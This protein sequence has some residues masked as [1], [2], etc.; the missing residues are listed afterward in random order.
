MAA[1]LPPH[2]QSILS[3]ISDFEQLR[4]SA[5]GAKP[6]NTVNPFELPV[7]KPRAGEG[8]KPAPA[9]T[10]DV[11]EI[12]FPNTGIKL[13]TPVMRGPSNDRTLSSRQAITGM[14]VAERVATIAACINSGD[15]DRAEVLYHRTARTTSREEMKEVVSTAMINAFVDAFLDPE[16]KSKLGPGGVDLTRAREWHGRIKEYDMAPDATTYAI[17]IKHALSIND[18]PLTIEFVKEMEKHGLDTA[19]LLE[20]RRFS[21]PEDRAPLESLLRGLGRL[22]LGKT[23][24]PESIVEKLLNTVKDNNAD[25]SMLEDSLMLSAIRD[26][27]EK[28]TIEEKEEEEVRRDGSKDVFQSPLHPLQAEV[29]K[30][31][32][33][34]GVNVLRKALGSLSRNPSMSPLERQRELEEKSLLAAVEE[35]EAEMKKMPAH[36]REIAQTRTRLAKEW[37]SLLVPT[38]K[39]ELEALENATSDAEEHSYV[40]FLRLLTPEQMS[41][42][43]ITEFLRLPEKGDKMAEHAG[44]TTFTRLLVSIGKAIEREYNMQQLS[45]PKNRKHIHELHANGKLFNRTMRK[46]ISQFALKDAEDEEKENWIPVWPESVY[47]KAASVLSV[48]LMRVAKI[49]VLH[50]KKD[51]PSEDITVW[52]PAFIHG[53]EQKDL[54][55]YGVI[56]YNPYL[57]EKLAGDPI[58]VSPRLL[59]MIIKPRPW[60]TANSGGYVDFIQNAVRTGFNKEHSDYIKQADKEQKLNKVYHCLDVLGATPWR[61]NERVYDVIRQVW[62]DG[63]GAAGIPSAEIP[64]AMPLKPK[65]VETWDVAK[66]KA[67]F[68]ERRKVESQRMTMF[69]Q[70]CDVNYKIEIARAFL[71]ETIYFPHNLDFRGRAYPMP[72]HLNH[73]GN[74]VCRGLLLFDTAKPL[75]PTGLRWLKIQVASLAGNDKVSFQDRI[76]FADEH[77]DDIFDAADNPLGGRRWWMGGEE[78]WQLLACCFELADALRSPKPEEF[79]SRMP[80]HQDGTCNGLQ[81][82]AALGGDVE[83]ARQVNLL[84]SDKPEDIYSAVMRKVA[85]KI[86]EGAENGCEIALKMKGKVTR[87]LVKQTVMTNTYGVTFVGA[88][89]QVESRLKENPEFYGI[90][91]PKDLLAVSTHIAKLIFDGMDQLFTGARALQHWLNTAARLISKT[92]E[93]ENI[94][95]LQVQDAAFFQELGC[96]PTPFTVARAE[97]LCAASEKADEDMKM[98]L[99]EEI[100]ADDPSGG[101]AGDFD[102]GDALIKAAMKDAKKRAKEEDDLDGYDSAVDDGVFDQLVTANWRRKPDQMKS[103]IWT[104]PL[105][106]PIVQP[107]RNRKTKQVRTMIQTFNV[108]DTTVSMPVDSSKQ[109]TAFPPNFIHSLD[110]AHMMESATRCQAAG[111]EFASVHDSYWTHACDVQKM[112][113]ILR[114]AF[115]DL[116]SRDIMVGLRNELNWRQKGC[117]FPIDIEISDPVKLQAYK[118]HLI[119]T[120]RKRSAKFNPEK[121]PRKFSTWVD[122]AL[123]PLPAKGELDLKRVKESNYFFH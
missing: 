48:L 101:G 100:A 43:T 88:R 57:L 114:D 96:L 9:L 7:A 29:L 79:L 113:E 111:I 13:P 45:K 60:V 83:G 116:H 74:D 65:G 68:A 19:E 10:S 104:T 102:D 35:Q 21:E 97:A 50:A 63:S 5:A 44:A 69:S 92:V 84:P 30:K 20:N 46:V 39:T 118:D 41:K 115:V 55:Q 122:F 62:N 51:N 3:A 81:H 22:K 32:D 8:K 11:E 61:I 70:R 64:K 123:P 42:I 112:N 40:P 98:D 78:P 36:L 71:G 18:M 108:V 73:I 17:L 91:D 38:I 119:A 93:V 94:T 77:L 75:G 121:G 110:A 95:P 120:G 28:K 24:K 58:H 86:D 15:V 4:K 82:Y 59:P 66:R 89:A 87:K 49:P 12:L 26:A 106:L 56:K 76:L 105:D 14:V 85:E 117:K 16:R 107:Y 47:V 2:K 27:S 52:E 31:T 99:E 23:R 37:N 90:T 54:K 72:S 103:V 53:M 1:A 25:G 33:A 34:I 80:I 6:F 109:S 67:Y